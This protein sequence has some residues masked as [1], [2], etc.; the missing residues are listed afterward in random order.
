MTFTSVYDVYGQDNIAAEQQD[1]IAESEPL[2]AGSDK[3]SRR[4]E[5]AALM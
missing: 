5:M 1:F 2:R 4:A 3:E